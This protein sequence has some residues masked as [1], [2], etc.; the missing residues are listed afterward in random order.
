MA[1]QNAKTLWGAAAI[2]AAYVRN[3]AYTRT[4]PNETPMERWSGKRPNVESLHEFGTP[5][6]VLNEAATKDKLDARGNIHVF[7]GFEEGPNAIRYFD[8][9]TRQVKVSRNYQFLPKANHPPCFEGESL[10]EDESLWELGESELAGGDG[11]EKETEPLCIRI[12][13]RVRDEDEEERP[14]KRRKTTEN[15]SAERTLCAEII[16]AASNENCIIARENPRTLKEAEESDEWSEWEKAEGR[17]A[18]GNKWVFLKKFTKKIP[19][20]DYSQ[21]FSPVVRMETIWMI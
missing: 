13:R 20:M 9:Q 1:L 17:R 19:G 3:H 2:H 6:A 16:Y 4:L 14:S 5:V 11:K 18:V 21:T 7:V 10:E 12:P 15:I 8:I